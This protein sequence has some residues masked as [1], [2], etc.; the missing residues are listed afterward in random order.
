MSHLNQQALD[1]RYH[2]AIIPNQRGVVQQPILR[3]Q[4]SY[5]TRAH[6]QFIVGYVCVC[7]CAC[8]CVVPCS[9]LFKGQREN[10]RLG[11]LYLVTHPCGL[12]LTTLN[13]QEAKAESIAD[14]N[15]CLWF[16]GWLPLFADRYPL[17]DRKAGCRFATGECRVC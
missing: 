11:S 2:P 17:K 16:I 1:C 6:Q 13:N 3:Q 9:G 8:A 12:S 10:H 15:R 4:Q 7:V 5:N 14:C